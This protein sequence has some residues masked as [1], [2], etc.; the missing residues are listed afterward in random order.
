M[1]GH[2][3]AWLSACQYS[4]MIRIG[5]RGEQNS[6]Y[7]IS[8]LCCRK[9]P[10]VKTQLGFSV[11]KQQC[12]ASVCICMQRYLVRMDT[13]GHSEEATGLRVQRTCTA[14]RT[15]LSREYSEAGI[16]QVSCLCLTIL[17]LYAK[18]PTE[19]SPLVEADHRNTENRNLTARLL[20]HIADSCPAAARIR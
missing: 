11:S 6:Q 10:T 16:L 4:R 9:F 1:I 17:V 19:I 15:A 8:Q 18:S 20:L 14:V 12:I 5:R 2:G 7:E 13:H 3:H